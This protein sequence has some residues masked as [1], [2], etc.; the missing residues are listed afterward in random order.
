MTRTETIRNLEKRYHV[1][2]D[3]DFFYM[4]LSGERCE[5]FKI[6]TRDG[7]CWDKVIGYRSLIA[8]LARDKASLLRIAKG[9]EE[10]TLDD[11]TIPHLEHKKPIKLSAE[12]Y[13]EM[14]SAFGTGTTVVNV[15][16]GQKY[17][18]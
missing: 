7:C 4:P 10:T 12:E 8:T 11:S 2:I 9:E 3:R 14:Q 18:L 13:Y 16:T 5:D 17:R 6:Y 15:L 1:H